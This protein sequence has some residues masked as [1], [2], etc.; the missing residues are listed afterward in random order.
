MRAQKIWYPTAAIV[1]VQD[2]SICVGVLHREN[3]RL[4]CSDVGL[5]EFLGRS[6]CSW[7]RTSFP[8]THK[9]Q[10]S[11]SITLTPAQTGS[12][13]GSITMEESDADEWARYYYRNL[14]PG[15]RR[16]RE[17]A[18]PAPTAG[19]LRRSQ[20][21]TNLAMATAAPRMP[22]SPSSSPR[23]PSP[24]PMPEMQFG[25]QSPSTSANTNE[26]QVDTQNKPD[27]S[28]RRRIRPGTRAA[29]MARGPPLVPLIQV[30]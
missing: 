20:T 6:G 3:K 18:T 26:L 9:V 13:P 21:H 29:D 1:I 2:A 27:E 25:P 10:S 8:A 24:P 16:P 11:L 17:Y 22:D 4:K 7:R 19:L 30:R 12:L 23:L 28:A 15:H 14:Y 5:Q